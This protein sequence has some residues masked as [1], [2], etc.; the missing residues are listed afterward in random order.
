MIV[1]AVAGHPD[2]TILVHMDA[3][4]GGWPLVARARPSP[5]PEQL[6]VGGELQHWRRGG[7][8]SGLGWILLGALLVIGQR[9]RP[10]DDPDIVLAVSGDAGHLAKYPI[11]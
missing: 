8:T 7:A 11:V 10:L 9:R 1:L 3:V 6:A 2:V 4:L 5:A